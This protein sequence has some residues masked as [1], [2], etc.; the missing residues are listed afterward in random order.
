MKKKI[1]PVVITMICLA[2]LGII[3]VQFFWIRN[4]VKVKEEQFNRSVNDAMILAL[5]R[6]ETRE[7]LISLKRSRI[8]DSINMLVEAFSKDPVLNLNLKLDS[9]LE[10]EALLPWER[11]EPQSEAERFYIEYSFR[12]PGQ[13]PEIRHFEYFPPELSDYS[14]EINGYV[15]FQKLDSVMAS[16]DEK[17][18]RREKEIIK[19]ESKAAEHRIERQRTEVIQNRERMVFRPENLPPPPLPPGD[20]GM[21][22]DDMKRITNKARKIKEMIQKM[23]VELESK[24]LSLAERIDTANINTVLKQS[25]AEKG[26]ESNF[27][28]ALESQT[29]S[30]D[31][32]VLQSKGF[33]P[34]NIQKAHKASL[35]A[36]DIFRKKDQLLLYF[37]GQKNIITDSVSW[38]VIGSV[39]FT[40]III[41]TSVLSIFIMLRQKKISEIKTDFIN[42]MTHEFKTPIATI[43]IAVDSINNSKVIDDPERIRNYTRVIK[44]ENTRMNSRVEQVLQMA[45]LDSSEFRINARPIDIHTVLYKVTDQFRL[46]IEKRNG[47]LEFFSGAE[48]SVVRGDDSHLSAVFLN[49][50]DNANKYS[51]DKP[52]ITVSTRNSGNMLIIDVEDKGIGMNSE[53]RNKIFEKFY[54]V[55]TGNIH[56]IKG[57]GLGLSYVRALV[58]AHKG[59]IKVSS[60]PGKGSCFTIELPVAS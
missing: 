21:R 20:P 40:L 56:N 29:D 11:M 14:F 25:L 8:G 30:S 18:S 46:Q 10:N 27:E 26:I 38:V 3:G 54:R 48:D 47:S 37:P 52:E 58:L 2:L 13:F 59:V 33:R 39:F 24:P 1:L 45:L 9:L 42:N 17:R 41:I 22:R 51:P 12:E 34:S 6:L 32:I 4:A 15:D 23:A 44:E 43:S 5:S 19:H 31:S 49:L 28:Y 35:F 60:E 7:D 16:L 53:T 50:L 36:D 55:T 57:F